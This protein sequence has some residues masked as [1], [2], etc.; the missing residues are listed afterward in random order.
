MSLDLLFLFR[1]DA[2]QFECFSTGLLVVFIF[3]TVQF[4]F[5]FIN[6]ALELVKLFSDWTN[7]VVKSIDGGLALRLS[8]SEHIA[9][10]F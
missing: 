7:V 2:F 8:I 10:Y 4:V 1:S 5:L 3:K 9:V 6:L